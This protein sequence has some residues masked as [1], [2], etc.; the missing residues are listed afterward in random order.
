MKG[1][2]SVI[3][4]VNTN[5][6]E[7]FFRINLECTKPQIAEGTGISLVT[8]IK[9]VNNLIIEKK[10]IEQGSIDSTGGRRAK[11]YKWNPNAEHSIGLYYMK[12]MIYGFVF[13]A[14]GTILFQKSFLIKPSEHIYI[15][16]CNAINQLINDDTKGTIASIGLGIPG[17]CSQGIICSVFSIPQLN[18]YP[19]IQK[20]K[21]QFHI[22][23]LIENDINL[24]AVGFYLNQS[25]SIAKDL[26]LLY[27]EDGVG[28]GIILNGNLFSG[29][30]SFAGEIGYLPIES[31]KGKARTLEETIRELRIKM[32]ETP[33]KKDLQK[34]FNNLIAKA[35]VS[36][37]C[38][39]NPEMIAIT[40]KFATEDIQQIRDEINQTIAIDTIP[41]IV[42]IQDIHEYCIR[43]IVSLCMEYL[44][45]DNIQ[46]NKGEK[47]LYE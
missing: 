45:S 19:L 44:K 26:I 29:K 34:E 38:V 27:M 12:G 20:L 9:I 46:L 24:A 6:V 33:L 41:E 10:V 16:T 43:G 5:L 39:L 47:I 23:V 22:P 2:P 32:K 42:V 18:G 25:D 11:L 37:I 36:V 8:V 21:E 17:V 35:M 1:T 28:S 3:K 40:G 14:L 30:T 13:D 15:T 7:E 31:H 4:N